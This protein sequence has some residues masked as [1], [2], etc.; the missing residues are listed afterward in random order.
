MNCLPLNKKLYSTVKQKVKSKVKVWPS[1]YASGQLV[2]QY[3]AAGGKYRCNTRKL[4]L[5]DRWFKEKWVN[6]CTKPRTKCARSSKKYPY[7]RPSVKVSPKTPKT[8]KELGPQ[9]IKRMCKKKVSAKKIYL[10]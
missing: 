7:C 2:K 9:K 10:K 8:V 6:V 4:S 1:A 5:L 3:K